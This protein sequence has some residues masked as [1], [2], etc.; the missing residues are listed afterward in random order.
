MS[1][2]LHL[3]RLLRRHFL[4]RASDDGGIH[5]FDRRHR[6]DTSGLL[7]ARDLS[8]GHAHDGSNEGY[9]A[10]APSLFEQALALWHTTLDDP[11]LENS[12]LAPGPSSLSE[13]T[14][15]DLGC[16]KGRVLMLAADYPFRAVLGVELNPQLARIARANLNRWFRVPHACTNVR[17]VA[18]DILELA[19]PPG[20]VLLYLFN[21]FDRSVARA[22]VDELENASRTRTSPID[23]IYMHPDQA[24]LFERSSTVEVLADV[25]LPFS[26][27]DAQADAFHV[28]TDRCA[29]YRLAAAGTGDQRRGLPSRTNGV[30]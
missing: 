18:G 27:E 11:S 23:V 22:F 1:L 4:G 19:L 2:Y 24:D 7:Y 10:T 6:V 17:V 26:E 16:G 20:P 28:S 8:T 9:Y 3:R 15:I 14:F 5:P 30:R 12:A 21:A 29:M 13:Y 25:D